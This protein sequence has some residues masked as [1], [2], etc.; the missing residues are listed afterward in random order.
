[1]KYNHKKTI[2]NKKTNIKFKIC[3]LL[4]RSNGGGEISEKPSLWRIEISPH[5]Q[6]NTRRHFKKYEKVGCLG[7]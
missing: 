6:I 4:G 7:I 2:I 5:G 1:M 3:K